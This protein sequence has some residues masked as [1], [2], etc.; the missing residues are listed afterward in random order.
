[1]I[2]NLLTFNL[3]TLNLLTFNLP[4]F[5][6]QPSEGYSVRALRM[7][8]MSAVVEVGTSTFTNS[9]LPP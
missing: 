5:N 2:S 3:L 8:L 1:M 4:T 7:R 6:L 9:T